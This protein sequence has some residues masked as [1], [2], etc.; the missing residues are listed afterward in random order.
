MANKSRRRDRG[1]ISSEPWEIEYV[2]KQFPTH[3]HAEIESA[4][5]EVKRQL[6]GSEDR[7]KIMAAISRK[8]V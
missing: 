8:F 5:T 7:A 4:L 3:S 6:G 2:H 1:L